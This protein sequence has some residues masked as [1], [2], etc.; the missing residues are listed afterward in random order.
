MNPSYFRETYRPSPI[1]I[2][3]S[4]S[5]PNN[6]PPSQSF[7][8]TMMSSLLGEGSPDGWLCITIIEADDNSKAPLKTSLGSVLHQLDQKIIYPHYDFKHLT[9]KYF[10]IGMKPDDFLIQLVKYWDTGLSS[11]CTISRNITGVKNMSNYLGWI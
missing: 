1:M 8:V 3:S 7:S 5:I 9:G 4:T 10:E 6:F 2:W 11:S